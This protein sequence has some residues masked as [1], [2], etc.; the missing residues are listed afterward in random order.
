MG[1]VKAVDPGP[2]GTLAPVG[3]RKWA[4]RL[5]DVASLPTRH[6]RRLR[7]LA[8]AMALRGGGEERL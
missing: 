1:E 3:L 6:G 2:L 5:A 8:V 7:A 4:V